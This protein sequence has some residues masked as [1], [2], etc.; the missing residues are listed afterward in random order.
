M[1]TKLHRDRADIVGITVKITA[2]RSTGFLVRILEPFRAAANRHRDSLPREF[3]LIYD[4]IKYG[5][6]FANHL[7]ETQREEDGVWKALRNAA[8]DIDQTLGR[9]GGLFTGEEAEKLRT[10]SAE[11]RQVMAR[12]APRSVLGA[13]V[14]A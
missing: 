13:A 4:D 11:I 8:D 1:P 5:I 3:A 2:E 7:L 9:F 12:H 10:V 14:V 6:W